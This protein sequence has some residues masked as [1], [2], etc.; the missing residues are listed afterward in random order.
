MADWLDSFD[1]TKRV[2]VANFLDKLSLRLEQNS[3]KQQHASIEEALEDFAQRTG[4][5]QMQKRALR[6]QAMLKLAFDFTEV[7]REHDLQQVEFGDAPAS[8]LPG[9]KPGTENEKKIE[10]KLYDKKIDK[11]RKKEEIN[12]GEIDLGEISRRDLES[13]TSVIGSL[14]SKAVGGFKKVKTETTPQPFTKM[15][16]SRYTTPKPSWKPDPVKK[17]TR[18]ERNIQDQIDSMKISLRRFLDESTG[19]VRKLDKNEWIEYEEMK[20]QLAQ[21]QQGLEEF[22]EEKKQQDA[23]DE[24]DHVAA[25]NDKEFLSEFD[26]MLG[27]DMS[28]TTVSSREKQRTEKLKQITENTLYFGDESSRMNPELQKAFE[29]AAI[30]FKREGPHEGLKTYYKKSQGY[31]AMMDSG[32]EI[33]D[34][35]EC[36]ACKEN[37]EWNKT[38]SEKEQRPD[39]SNATATRR[40]KGTELGE[41][42]RTWINEKDPGRLS[43]EHL[44]SHIADFKRDGQLKEN[45]EDVTK[46]YRQ[47]LVDVYLNTYPGASLQSR[48]NEFATFIQDKINSNLDRTRDKQLLLV[49]STQKDL[50][51]TDDIVKDLIAKRLRNLEVDW[52]DASQKNLVNKILESVKNKL[53]LKFPHLDLRGNIGRIGKGHTDVPFSAF[54][55][56]LENEIVKAVEEDPDVQKMHQRRKTKSRNILRTRQH[57][58][59][60]MTQRIKDY[61]MKDAEKQAEEEK[62]KGEFK[63]FLKAKEAAKWL[64][65]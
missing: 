11:N 50:N 63:E 2:V 10:K 22:R 44:K 8:I 17:V 37:A 61:E 43:Y 65:S 47:D 19:E 64:R 25:L 13:M 59:W 9:V 54:Y 23:I 18:K 29:Q 39:R 7:D 58:D 53:Q 60:V 15:P 20:S 21:L 48:E 57:K 31:Y 16:K 12:K 45:P 62:K 38:H 56:T 42:Y 36:L 30:T 33:F 1:N 32:V 35:V 49:S 4:L 28:A 52:V 5:N 27:V 3:K 34:F 6:R 26:K 55:G 14:T 51:Y 24:P 41:P 46:E 40:I